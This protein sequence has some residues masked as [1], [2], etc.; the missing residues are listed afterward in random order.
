MFYVNKVYAQFVC[1]ISSKSP[2]FFEKSHNVENNGIVYP[3]PIN[4]INSYYFGSCYYGRF[5][6]D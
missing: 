2:N 4:V 5:P 6:P 1:L 3:P